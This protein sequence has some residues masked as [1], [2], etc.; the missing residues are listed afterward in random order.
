MELPF[1]AISLLQ[2]PCRAELL[3]FGGTQVAAPTASAMKN[4]RKR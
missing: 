3:G 2:T 4:G 1:V